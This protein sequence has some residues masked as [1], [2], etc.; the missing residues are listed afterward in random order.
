MK[1]FIIAVV[2]IFTS[3]ITTII[4]LETKKYVIIVTTTTTTTITTT[5]AIIEK[6]AK[7]YPGQHLFMLLR[8]TLSISSNNNNGEIHDKFQ[9]HRYFHWKAVMKLKLKDTNCQVHHLLIA[10]DLTLD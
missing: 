9:N 6:I 7:G 4:Q 3:Q 2:Q 10:M 1:M 8:A 5:T